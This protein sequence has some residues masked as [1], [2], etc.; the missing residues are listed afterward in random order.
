MTNARDILN[1]A[2]SAKP[3]ESLSSHREAV[4]V[5]RDKGYSW[6]EIADFLHER[7][8]ETDHTKLYRFMQRP[9]D[10]EVPSA[11]RYVEVLASLKISAVQLK[12]LE[13]HYKAH[14]RAITYTEL[15]KA[16]GADSHR[17]ANSSYGKLGRTLGEAL[18]MNFFQAGESPF[19]SSSLG[20]ANP[21]RSE[22]SHFQLVMHHEL[23]K[24]IQQLGWFE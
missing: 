10:F 18:E 17:A 19:Y 14:N 9:D 16:S 12:M 21:F 24:A 2:T 11:D 1:D 13:A 6:R 5:L 7:G 8:V 3:R 4:K 22:G 15:A 23:A 20:M